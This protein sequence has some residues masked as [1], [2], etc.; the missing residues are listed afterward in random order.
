[1][2]AFLIFTSLILILP[3]RIAICQDNTLYLMPGIPQANQLNPAYTR[4]CGTYI[5]L[6][7]ISSVKVNLRNSG[8]GFHDVFYAG[9]GVQS[10]NY[11]LDL[12]KLD[13]QLKRINYFQTETDIDLLG[14]GFGVKD[15]YFTFGVAN[16]SDLLLSYPH[17]IVLLNDNNLQAADSK[18]NSLNLNGLGAEI[19]IWNSI[20]ISAAKEVR[21]GL[22]IG[23]RL[24]YLQGMANAIARRSEISINTT[25]NPVTLDAKME[26]RINASFPVANRNRSGWSGEQSEFRQ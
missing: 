16:H 10:D 23:V 25:N 22:K 9:T 5:E 24:K 20:G 26:Y 7:V 1:M 17:D 21:Q 13:K 11:F 3:Y 18:L 2:L 19:T 8:F 6:P 12:I 14:L 15:W 4:P